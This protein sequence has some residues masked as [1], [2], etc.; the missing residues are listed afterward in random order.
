[1]LISPSS[2][3]KIRIACCANSGDLRY[4]FR[5]AS[6]DFD[7]AEV[8]GQYVAELLSDHAP[9]A[10]PMIH[11]TMGVASRNVRSP[12]AA[13]QHSPRPGRLKVLT[14][15]DPANY[16]HM[17]TAPMQF[18]VSPDA[19]QARMSQLLLLR[20]QTEGAASGDPSNPGEPGRP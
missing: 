9:R 14:L 8:S 4:A 11:D 20:G 18:P 15:E 12:P 19:P 5:V 1:M 3:G 13:S 6:A 10:A 2:H 16:V 17:F 7:E